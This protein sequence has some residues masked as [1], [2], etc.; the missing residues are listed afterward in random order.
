MTPS[1]MHKYFV[2]YC[3][4]IIITIGSV[5]LPTQK[6][7]AQCD[8]SGPNSDQTAP[9]LKDLPE[10]SIT[11]L[12]HEVPAPP[13]VISW[14]NCD[15]DFLKVHFEEKK[16]G[17]NCSY[18]ITRTWW[19]KDRC[20]NRSEFTQRIQAAD[21]K[22]PTL[23][24]VPA[25]VTVQ[26]GA[27]PEKANVT[28]KDDCDDNVQLEFKEYIPNPG[29]APYTIVREWFARD[30]CGNKALEK[31]K[32]TVL[33]ST[34]PVLQGIPSQSILQIGCGEVPPVP[35]VTAIDNCDGEIPVEF[36]EKQH[37]EGCS[38]KIIR[39]WQ[40]VDACDNY[41]IFTQNI[42][43]KDSEAPNLIGVPNDATV[44][45][46]TIP[47]PP[48]VI[49]RDDCSGE[50]S[51]S[52]SEYEQY[53]YTTEQ[54][55]IIR[56]WTAKDEC[57]N[58]A[59]DT[60]TLT[61][62][63]SESPTLLGLPTAQSS[64]N[65]SDTDNNGFPEPPPVTASDNCGGEV[66]IQFTQ[67]ANDSES[68]SIIRTWTATDEA[69]N[70]SS[71]TQT[72]AINDDTPPQLTGIPNDIRM[73]CRDNPPHPNASIRATDDCDDDVD[74]AF[75]ETV[76]KT[77]NCPYYI[78]RTWTAEDNCGNTASAS[79]TITVTDD[80]TPMLVG[81]PSESSIWV[82]CG[83]IPS[84]P[85]VVAVDAC[86]KDINVQFIEIKVA[87]N[88]DN[89]SYNL[90]RTWT[91]TDDCGN[92]AEF[93]QIIDVLD[94]MP[95]QLLDLPSAT[96]IVACG[97]SLPPPPTVT[98]RDNCDEEVEVVFQEVA[99][100]MGACSGIKRTW[101]ATDKCGN[102]ATFTQTI[103]TQDSAPP[104]LLGLPTQQSILN[105]S[106]VP[107][108]PNVIARD[109]CSGEVPVQF[110]EQQQG[111]G[112]SF[113]IQRTWTATD[114]CGN[115]TDFTQTIKVSADEAPALNGLPTAA[116]LWVKCG[117]VPLVQ[118]VVTAT[119]NCNNAL[120][121]QFEEVKVGPACNYSLQRTW[122]V[123]DACGHTNSFTQIIDVMDEMPP[124][125]QGLPPTTNIWI[126]CDEPIPA[127]A[128]VTAYDACDG[129]VDVQFVEIKL[130]AHDNPCT[131][132]LHRTWTAS[133]ACGNESTFTQI[134]D[135][136]DAM[137]PELLGLPE[138]QF[139]TL[140]CD[141]LPVAPNVIARDD[142]SGEVPVHFSETQTGEG[143][144][145]TLNRTWS[146]MDNCGNS[147]SF[148]QTIVVNGESAPVLSG[149]PEAAL[150]VKCGEVPSVQ[151]AVTASNNCNVALN[152]QFTEEQVGPP[153]NYSLQ[154]TWTAASA[155]GGTASSFTQVI[156]VMDNMG[157]QFFGLPPASFAAEC[158]TIPAVPS[159]T[160]I[161]NCQ[162]E[163]VH[164]M[165]NETQISE[166][167]LIR[168]WG[169]VDACGNESFFAQ[170]IT[171]C[172]QTGKNNTLLV[173][174]NVQE[175]EDIDL[176]TL[177]IF[178]NPAKNYIQASY[179]IAKGEDAQLILYDVSGK[180]LKV[181]PLAGIGK[182]E[183]RFDLSDLRAG[184]YLLVLQTKETQQSKKFMK[185]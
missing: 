18:L 90:H 25:D 127:I 4:S 92:T 143:C 154:R 151:E 29:H 145:F 9:M 183:V 106:N 64:V 148:T 2:Y 80:T 41:T 27:I 129:F 159:V 137:P 136:M 42:F 23:S 152:V 134:I 140:N 135:V 155:C 138:A 14:D 133:D 58:K 158:G 184:I 182:Q 39:R 67:E 118:E 35:S 93:S 102:R 6:V 83:E 21:T 122:S 87:E 149:L 91:A 104:E 131:Y 163:A 150:W 170:T 36:T 185:L 179:Q 82:K 89:C 31:Q 40:A 3:F 142:C 97:A 111:E 26:C 98:A 78:I 85:H 165:F 11:V 95:P 10:K 174:E 60:Q 180:Q 20:G 17:Q 8:C 12:C 141:N 126:K 19:T 176:V 173:K 107:A 73:G 75:A 33:D 1:Y 43:V 7:Y 81:L 59:T 113:T 55:D 139:T 77:G 124:V 156:D 66:N 51:V 38:Y 115:T 178:P 63:D 44:S 132:N 22:P 34:K 109:D 99:L 175:S 86:D 96:S 120:E 84:V 30:E 71:F 54:Y 166:T 146:A 62:G 16:T 177:S 117:E 167:T 105:C 57:N 108:P 69:G 47:N 128:N 119:D 153:C 171:L 28:V 76:E 65:C 5:C 50:V 168:A 13:E 144:N 79:Q 169:A 103:D 114:D 94:N 15:G 157:P 46:N 123:A 130:D 68:C 100:G 56:T 181:E 74:I 48:N 49:A 61:I 162:D 53:N 125:L 160:A 110:N 72:I 70:E 32:I 172:N 164:V 147:D 101:T 37:G 112:C 45:C 88:D 52:F 161:D 116:N 24:G 121:V